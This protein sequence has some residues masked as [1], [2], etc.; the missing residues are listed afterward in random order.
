[1]STTRIWKRTRWSASPFALAVL[2]ASGWDCG[3]GLGSVAQH[4]MDPVACSP[5]TGPSNFT[6]DDMGT[7]AM[8]CLSDAE[9]R[10]LGVPYPD[11][12]CSAGHQCTYDKCLQDEDCGTSGVCSC[13]GATRGWAGISPGN[14]CVPGNCRKDLD[15]GLHGF[16]SPSVGFGVGP[17]YGV[18]GYYCHTSRDQCRNDGTC[19]NRGYCAYDP[20]SGFWACSTMWS[21]G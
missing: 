21:A 17:F 11:G 8:T 1:M 5:T 4:R 13:Q 15:C 12:V 18:A 3:D 20:E 6:T 10:D 9:C 14:T 7:L 19:G 16:C 2:S